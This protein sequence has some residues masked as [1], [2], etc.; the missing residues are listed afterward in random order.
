MNPK[1]F[2]GWCTSGCGKSINKGVKYC[3]PAC[4]GRAHKKCFAPQYPCMNG[5]GKITSPG[6]RYCS[7]QCASADRAKIGTAEFVSRGGAY[8]HVN[9]HF[10]AKCLRRHLGE[11]CSRCGWSE[12]HPKTGK[13]PVEVEH[14][15]GDWQNNR[16]A[17]LTLLCPNCHALTPT[18]RGLNRGRGR[19]YR[20]G[21][22]ENP[23]N[24]ESP[25]PTPPRQTKYKVLGLPS[26]QLELWMPT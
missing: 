24:S 3:S 26:P 16:L 19:P 5:C 21:G 9:P 4:S 12:R 14:I 6:R 1:K 20:L 7:C 8:G 18:F 23:L 25:P 11:H 15:D 13:V 10:V 22:R 17:N 2:R